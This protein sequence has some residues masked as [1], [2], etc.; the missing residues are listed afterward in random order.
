MRYRRLAGKKEEEEEEV[1]RA[2]ARGGQPGRIAGSYRYAVPAGVPGRVC[3]STKATR[4]QTM[5]SR[6]PTLEFRRKA[7]TDA[8]T[9][10]GRDDDDD[11]DD[12]DDEN[13]E[14]RRG[15]RYRREPVAMMNT[16]GGGYI[17]IYVHTRR[18]S[19]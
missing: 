14:R 11:D 18:Y 19:T 10:Q 4:R 1:V 6:H 15:E 7:I 8:A 3:I 16:V 13:D 12:D 9:R 5:R 17:Y 2:R